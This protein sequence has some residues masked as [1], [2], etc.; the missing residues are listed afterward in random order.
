[1]KECWQIVFISYAVLVVLYTWLKKQN[2]GFLIN[3][4]DLFQ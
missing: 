4:Y 1:M 3:E 2:A